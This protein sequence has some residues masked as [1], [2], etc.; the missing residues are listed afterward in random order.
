V[1]QDE[2]V[3]FADGQLPGLDPY[4]VTAWLV[5]HTPV[6][7]PV[8][9][10]LIAAGG[11]NLT[12]RLTDGA[13]ARWV[14]RRPPVGQLLASAHDVTREHKILAGLWPSPVPVPEVAGVCTDADVT[15]APFF[16]MRYVEGLILR[17][18][19]HGVELGPERARVAGTNFFGALATIHTT[20]PASTGLDGLS[21]PD[22]YVERQLRR[23]HQQYQQTAGDDASPLEA[24]LHDRLAA[25]VPAD[26]VDGAAHLVHGD[27][28]I[29]NAVFDRD[30]KVIAVFDWELATLGHP[31]ADLAWS[32]LF[33]AEPGDAQTYL[34][35]AVT[36]APGF[37]TRAEVVEL[38]GKATGYDTTSLPYFEAFTNWKMGCLLS[39]S[40]YRSRRGEAGGMSARSS[41]DHDA[42]RQRLLGLF[43]AA[44][45]ILDAL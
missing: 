22:R 33:W 10:G 5:E 30:L 37:P 45:A 42:L 36:S 26:V 24:E 16:V 17:N 9:Y 32:L 12:Y 27:F 35:E 39:G 20:P 6:V 41:T 23:W 13:G 19:A 21:R 38:Y 44:A 11:S 1:A 31:I 7:A 43:D 25:S 14:L 28:H 15:G 3:E 29:D 34:A 8:E 4:R 40:L 18:T 2:V